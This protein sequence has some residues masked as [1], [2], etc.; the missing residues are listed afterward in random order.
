MRI[1]AESTPRDAVIRSGLLEWSPGYMNL[2]VRSCAQVSIGAWG[3]P[4]MEK[5]IALSSLDLE[6]A[7]L[8]R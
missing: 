6:A 5:I 1:E 4:P 7:L 2:P 3:I 8:E